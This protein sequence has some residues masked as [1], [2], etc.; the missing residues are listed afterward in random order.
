MP[1]TLIYR[2]VIIFVL[3]SFIPQAFASEQR[4]RFQTGFASSFYLDEFSTQLIDSLQGQSSHMPK[5]DGDA[6]RGHGAGNRIG[7]HL[8]RC[9]QG[10]QWTAAE[11]S[12]EYLVCRDDVE[13]RYCPQ[14]TVKFTFDPY[15]ADFYC[16]AEENYLS[17]KL[18]RPVQSGDETLRRFAR[19]RDTMNLSSRAF[20]KALLALDHQR[21]LEALSSGNEA[22]DRYAESLQ[23][24]NSPIQSSAAGNTSPVADILL[25]QIR[26]AVTLLRASL[27]R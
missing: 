15:H 23:I 25:Q 8:P 26:T 10:G 16:L 12:G 21:P 9:D 19:F 7:S 14:M 1:N 27:C 18:H 5:F 22:C 6:A 20:Q 4:K 13:Y 17:A 24:L 11:P 2:A 3:S